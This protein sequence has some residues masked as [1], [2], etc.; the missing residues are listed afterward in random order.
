MTTASERPGPDTGGGYDAIR[1]AFRWQDVLEMLGWSPDGDINV[2][3]TIADRHASTG[4]MAIDWRGRD[5]ERRT[6]SFADLASGSSRFAE[7]LA[8]LGVGKGDR[9]AM[10]M[11][12]VPETIIAMLG[13]WKAGAVYVPIFSAFGAEAIRMRLVDSGAKVLVTH[14][15]Y[16]ESL[17]P[18]RDAVS[19]VVVAGQCELETGDMGF[20]AAMASAA[21]GFEP[22]PVQRRDPAVLL[23]TSG[24]TGPPKGVAISANFVAAIAPGVR[25]CADLQP[26]DV[27]W[28][29]G[30]PAWGY[31]LVCYAVALAMGTAVVMW[32]AQ[33]TGE[34]ALE[35]MAEVGVTNLATV[36]T[37]LRA[38]MALGE[39]EVRAHGLPVRQI[40]SCG[41]PLNAEVVRFFREV[42]GATPLDTYGS[43]E[44]G[45]PVGNLAA[46][47]AEVRPGSMG[48]PL[49]G[50]T[51]SI[52]DESGRELDDGVVGLIGLAPDPQGFYAVS[53]WNNP[54]L[55]AEVFEGQWIVTNDLGRRDADGYLWFEGRSDDV[56][57]SAGYR[58]GPFE[59]ESA[60][61]EHPAVA[62][63]GVVGKPDS[64]RGHV[65]MAYVVLKP[66]VTPGEDLERELVDTVRAHLGAHAAPR[67][68]A[69]VAELPKTESGKI[70]R[71]K[72]RERAAGKSP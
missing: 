30:D 67:E 47:G 7:V 40:W 17:A 8:G 50:H 41:E 44:M 55:T 37:L 28:P 70:Q 33:P 59:V 10:V 6:L 15:E 22:V 38:V 19:S 16:R 58:I 21:D 20:D 2:A 43:S 3:A 32:Q 18:V 27:F 1:S 54:E 35:F 61:I 25:F 62:E 42:W 49:P 45:L 71:F 46:T 64:L 65:V 56:I 66:N 72:L 12:R 69:F 53:Y 48:R 26:D 36:P 14:A 52:V 23:Y 5:G 29:T 11:P 51:V 68:I 13:I 31:G 9:V 60:L 4:R 24:S 34:S 39:D 63:A 57:K